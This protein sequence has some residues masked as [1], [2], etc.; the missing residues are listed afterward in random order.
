MG[1][2]LQTRLRR[3]PPPPFA[4]HRL[5]PDLL[6]LQLAAAAVTTSPFAAL[7]RL[8]GCRLDLQRAIPPHHQER[9]MPEAAEWNDENT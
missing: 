5:G 9:K 2:R 3:R 1:R 4:Q 6:P 7:H 8:P